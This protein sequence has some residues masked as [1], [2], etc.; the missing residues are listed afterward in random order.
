LTLEERA[1]AAATPMDAERFSIITDRGVGSDER[2][3]CNNS[4]SAKVGDKV[5]LSYSN[6]F[7]RC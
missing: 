4:A 1:L 2:K 5:G 3:S 7:I 6:W